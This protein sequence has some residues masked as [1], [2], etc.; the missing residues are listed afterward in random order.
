[1]NSKTEKSFFEKYEF[2][3]PLAL[4]ILFLIF[5]LPGISWGAPDIWHPDEV[6][7]IS[8]RSLHTDLDFDSSNFN[9]PH[10]PIYTMLGLGKTIL[11]LGQTDKEVL[12]AARILS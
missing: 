10:L 6:V 4:F 2:I 1:M 7:Y 8:I 12:I 9:H 11:A 5:T 3:V